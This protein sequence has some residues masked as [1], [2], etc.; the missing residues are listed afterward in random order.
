MKLTEPEY[1]VLSRRGE[2]TQTI[3]VP[4]GKPAKHRK[5]A[6]WVALVPC[7][8]SPGR[9]YEAWA[10]V[11]GNDGTVEKQTLTV[12]VLDVIEL[13]NREGWDVT[14]CPRHHPYVP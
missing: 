13:E 14:A 1:R 5:G 11:R 6:G 8:V 12:T 2:K 4:R 7:P 3:H 9:A 10:K